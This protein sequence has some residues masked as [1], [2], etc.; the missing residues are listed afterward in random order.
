MK[1]NVPV[2]VHHLFKFGDTPFGIEW[3]KTQK[4]MWNMVLTTMDMPKVHS[5]SLGNFLSDCFPE[6]P[7]IRRSYF[8]R[9]IFMRGIN[10]LSPQQLTLEDLKDASE[11]I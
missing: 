2:N 11:V 7:T 10:G 8:D 6:E 4:G 1:D 9:N 3:W 5:D